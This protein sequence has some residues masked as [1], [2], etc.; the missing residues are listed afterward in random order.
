MFEERLTALHEHLMTVSAVVTEIAD[1]VLARKHTVTLSSHSS[2][3]PQRPTLPA[4]GRLKKNAL[5]TPKDVINAL[6]FPVETTPEDVSNIYAYSYNT[7]VLS[8][9]PRGQAR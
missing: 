9:I 1:D 7:N 4:L 8:Q 6:G 3:S 5:T 2:A